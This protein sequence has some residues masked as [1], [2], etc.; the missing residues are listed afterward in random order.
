MLIVVLFNLKADASPQ[1]YEAWAK[2]TDIPTVK[3]LGSVAG[4]SVS[5]VAGLLGSNDPAPY[6]YVELI[7]VGDM[8]AFGVDVASET[9]QRVAAEFQAFADNPCFLMTEPI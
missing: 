2:S 3:A 8:D 4:F 9:M 7:E 1:D 6:D 5:R